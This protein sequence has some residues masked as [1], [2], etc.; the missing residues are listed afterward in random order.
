MSAIIDT[1]EAALIEAVLAAL[2]AD[3]GVQAMFGVP[4]R[5]FD[6]DTDAPMYPFVELVSAE[7]R[8]IASTQAPGGEHRITFAVTTRHGGRA[9]AADGLDVLVRAVQAAELT[10]PGKAIVI[11]H[12]VYLDVMRGRTAQTFRGL[13]RLRI[14]TEEV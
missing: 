9:A 3:E 6:G 5:I 12:P 8:D 13:L 1:G 14:L 11:V 2:R 7:T 10:L 4:A